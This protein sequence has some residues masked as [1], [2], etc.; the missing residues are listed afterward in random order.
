MSLEQAIKENTEATAALAIT[1]NNFVASIT[2]TVATKEASKKTTSAPKKETAPAKE[3]KAEEVKEEK[4]A[5]A[6][7]KEPKKPTVKLSD[8][9]AVAKELVK[10]GGEA[11]ASAKAAIEE[12]GGAGAKLSTL[13]ADQYPAVLEALEAVKANL[14]EEEI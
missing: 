12:V 1:L 8:L 14:D 10:A 9:Q 13:E 5:A 7:K 6:P 4:P 3:E 11:K 2:K